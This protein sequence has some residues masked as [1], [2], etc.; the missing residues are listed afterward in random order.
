MKKIGLFLLLLLTHY[1][2]KGQGF[3]VKEYKIDIFLQQEGYF[4]VVE[5]Y[6]VEFYEQKHGLIR[7]IITSYDFNTNHPNGISRRE[8]YISDIEVPGWNF[9]SSGKLAQRF[10][11]QISIKIGDADKLI[12]GRQHYEIKYRVKN[13]L[14]F[15]DSQVML[16][17][18]IKPTNWY[19]DFEQIQF[20]IHTPEGSVLNQQNCF[21]YS[22][23][24]GDTIPSLEFNTKYDNAVFSGLSKPSF[25]SNYGDAVTILVKLPKP[26]VAQVDFGPSPTQ[27]NFW[28]FI[29]G[30]FLFWFWMIWR[31][32]G[33]DEK[34]VQVTTYYPPE[35]IDP[36]MAGF[37]IN[38]R[39]DASDL[40]ALIPHWAAQG[41]LKIKEIP[42][43]WFLGKTD[44]Q[45]EQKKSL[46]NDAKNYEQTF[47]NGLFSGG[48]TIL[49][50][51]LRNKFY[52]TMN[53]S[54]TYLKNNAKVY[55]ESAGLKALAW[56][57]GIAILMAFLFSFVA[58]YIW[59]FIA[60]FASL[61]TFIFIA[62]MAFYLKK[63]NTQGN[64]IFADLKGFRQFIKLAEVDRIRALVA[65]DDKYFE[66]TMSYAMAFGLLKEWAAK[67]EALNIPPPSWYSGSS[68]IYSMNSFSQSFTST[69]SS[70]SSTMV[71][72]PSSSGSGG[73]SS[74]GGFGGGGGG[75]W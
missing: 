54:K 38:D 52:T 50:S 16:Y 5:N 56:V 35:G 13:A 36:A 43:T 3:N 20:N 27:Q 39:E 62:I 23:A 73:G 74:G 69:M 22:G 31:R 47:F 4:D 60:A 26:T 68:G 17:W 46:P 42:K 8:I 32:I 66:K 57:R 48:K 7:N 15:T 6:E 55:Y 19:A 75:S 30:G 18:N 49:I 63:K 67:F 61:A 51:S 53:T 72:T 44:M 71:S 65:E 64:Q 59:G 40:T 2:S 28:M 12:F 14:I 34:V 11:Q 24:A 25:I 21:V 45:L 70:A 33:R 41:I 29:L 10:D 58:F 1:W 9:T 37:L